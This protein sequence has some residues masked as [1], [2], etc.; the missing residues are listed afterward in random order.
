MLIKSYLTNLDLHCL[1]LC[2][3][4]GDPGSTRYFLSLEDNLFRIFGGD[5]IKTLMTTFGVADL[6]I[7]SRMLTSSLSEA[8][9]KVGRCSPRGLVAA[10]AV[11]V[12]VTRLPRASAGLQHPSAQCPYHHCVV[13]LSSC[14]KP[15]QDPV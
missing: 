7:E 5:R 8:Q 9:R 13:V 1:A 10:A 6:P 12:V 2:C 14:L 15:A 4:Q 11:V 3:R